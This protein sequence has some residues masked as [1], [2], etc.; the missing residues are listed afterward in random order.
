[1]TA[2]QKLALLT[3]DEAI[4]VT[5]AAL[6][7][8]AAVLC[9]R[10]PTT[11]VAALL[12]ERSSRRELTRAERAA[13]ATYRRALDGVRAAGHGDVIQDQVEGYMSALACDP[14]FRSVAA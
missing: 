4:G 11:T 9:V 2:A 12:R 6:D 7:T 13:V 3:A 5:V 8:A 10:L 1:M 14:G